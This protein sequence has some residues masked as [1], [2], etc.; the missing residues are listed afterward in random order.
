MRI[1]HL[2]DLHYGRVDYS[3]E[4]A[5]LDKVCSLEPDVV[6]V[7][8]DLTQRARRS[9]FEDARRFLDSLPCPHIFVPGNHDIPAEKFWRRWLTPFHMYKQVVSDNLEPDFVSDAV[10][11]KG[12][13][14][15]NRF[16]W[17]QGKLSLKSA[18]KAGLWART[19]EAGTKILTIHHP[20]EKI[21]NSNKN[22]MRGSRATLK[23]LEKE[24]FDIVLSGHV[25]KGVIKPFAENPNLL[26]V[27]VGTSLSNRLRKEANMFYVLDIDG[28]Q[29]HITDYTLKR[30]GELSFAEKERHEYLKT[31]TGWQKQQK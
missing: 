7:S 10:A 22:A 29:C 6:V 17:Q 2:S 23:V 16:S 4:I 5:L 21:Q 25:H 19:Q 11:I 27:Q 28:S 18:L 26:M 9:Q 30:N 24:G 12:L 3:I 8:G 13:N 14:T 31:P 20:L 1:V 15:V